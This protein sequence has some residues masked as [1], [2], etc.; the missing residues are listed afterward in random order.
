VDPH[1][2]SAPPAAAPHGS[3]SA[4]WLLRTA[5]FL[6]LGLGAV[7][8]VVPGLPTTP[9]VLVAAACFARSSPRLHRWLLA[10]R[11]FGP[12]IRNWQ[13][14]RSISP[15][16]RRTAISMIVAVGVLTVG[17]LLTNL[18]LRVAVAATMLAVIVWLSRLPVRQGD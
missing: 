1:P 3:R 9:L 2:G 16:A 14:H 12:L 17:F 5:G 4:R 15:R 8:V 6:F 13:E 7:G 18:I 11:V 10:N